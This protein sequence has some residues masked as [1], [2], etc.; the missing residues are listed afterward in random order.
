MYGPVSSDS[1]VIDV[2]SRKREKQQEKVHTDKE[3]MNI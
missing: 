2:L 1:I 3:T